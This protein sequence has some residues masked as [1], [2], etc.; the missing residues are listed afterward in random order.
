MGLGGAQRGNPFLTI[1]KFSACHP[2]AWQVKVWR[3]GSPG[4][5]CERVRAPHCRAGVGKPIA[6]VGGPGGVRYRPRRLV[7]PV[8]GSVGCRSVWPPAPPGSHLGGAPRRSPATSGPT[9]TSPVPSRACSTTSRSQCADLA[10]SSAFCDAVLSPL[11][12]ERVLEIGAVIGY[13]VNGRASFWL[14]PLAGGGPNRE[15]HV[16]FWGYGPIGRAGV[17]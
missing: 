10:A 8:S 6:G 9:G 4:H 12:G 17:L 1:P 5:Q 16:A 7:P 13:G 11:A 3:W 14:G 15:V 2:Q